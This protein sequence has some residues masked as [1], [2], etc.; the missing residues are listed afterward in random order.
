MFVS[1]YE[2]PGDFTCVWEKPVSSSLRA[3]GSIKGRKLSV[4]RLFTL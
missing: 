3:N 4:E 1:E 2:A